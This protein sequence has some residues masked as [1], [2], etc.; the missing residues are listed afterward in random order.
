M[1]MGCCLSLVPLWLV[2][3]DTDGYTHYKQGDWQ[4][5]SLSAFNLHAGLSRTD[6]LRDIAAVVATEERGEVFNCDSSGG[7]SSAEAPHCS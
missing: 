3:G 1:V 4:L 2:G 5:L 7:H 6:N